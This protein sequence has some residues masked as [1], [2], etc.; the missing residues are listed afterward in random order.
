M[1]VRVMLEPWEISKAPRK[2]LSFGT[3][4]LQRITGRKTV[5]SDLSRFLILFSFFFSFFYFL[6]APSTDVLVRLIFGECKSFKWKFK[7]LILI[8]SLEFSTVHQ[9]ESNTT[10]QCVIH[11]DSSRSTEFAGSAPSA[12]ITIYA[13][14]VIILISTIYATASIASR[15]LEFRVN[16]ANFLLFFTSSAFPVVIEFF[17]ILAENRRKLRFAESFKVRA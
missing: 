17:S 9:P 8:S 14:F 5:K 16:R 15:K 13:R 4:E 11:A 10:A 2:L 7:L 1:A 3:A 12:I 6:S